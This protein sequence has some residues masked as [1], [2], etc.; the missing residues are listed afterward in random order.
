MPEVSIEHPLDEKE[1]RMLA[2]MVVPDG[3]VDFTFDEKATPQQI[4]Q[5][6]KLCS[7]AAI[8]LQRKHDGLMHVVGK[9]LHVCRVTPAVYHAAG[10]E[11]FDLFLKQH[12]TE[13]LGIG[14]SSLRAALQIY[15]SF[16]SISPA[17]VAEV[18]TGKMQLLRRITDST[19]PSHR[20]L[21]EAAKT[22]TYSQLLQVAAERANLPPGEVLRTIITIAASKA[23][24]KMWREF[25]ENPK[26]RAKCETEDAGTILEYAIAE[27]LATWAPEEPQENPVP[28]NWDDL[29]ESQDHR[30]R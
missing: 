1:Q 17:E 8:I 14:K 4:L 18:G 9:I 28:V 19:Q 29:R 23:Q 5:S 30:G 24:G 16:P 10:Y 27:A 21:I 12:V 7:Q 15:E 26:V 25:V 11:S 6:L 2:G 20:P 22:Q 3:Q 13:V